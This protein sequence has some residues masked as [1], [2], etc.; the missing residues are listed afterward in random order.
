MKKVFALVLTAV[1]AFALAV[2]VMAAPEKSNPNQD[3]TGLTETAYD[4][5]EECVVDVTEEGVPILTVP[6]GYDLKIPIT[7]TNN[8]DRGLPQLSIWVNGEQAA[9]WGAVSKG[10]SVTYVIDVDTSAEGTYLYFVEIWTRRGNPN[11]EDVGVGAAIIIVEGEPES[12]GGEKSDAALLMDLTSDEITKGLKLNEKGMVLAAGG[13]EFVLC[14]GAKS[15]NQKGTVDL[16]DG[17]FL[18][19]DIA[20]NGKHI[21]QF[22]IT[23]R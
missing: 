4:L 6:V 8:A 23:K 10:E 18:I 11:Y 2:P 14:A 20:G 13:R 9:Y 16:G 19:F 22:D 1:M 15:L 12:D 3:F 7:F 21:K 17:Y 5:P